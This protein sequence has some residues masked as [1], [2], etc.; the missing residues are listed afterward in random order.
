MSF[1]TIKFT[2]KTIVLMSITFGVTWWFLEGGPWIGPQLYGPTPS[3][4]V[5]TF[6]EV[7]RDR[8]LM[9]KDRDLFEK[10]G[11]NSSDGNPK[12]DAL[13]NAVIDAS[14]IYRVKTCNKK[15]RKDFAKASWDYI[16]ESGSHKMSKFETP[17]DEKV[18]Y[19]I[20]TFLREGLIT[21]RE[22]GGFPWSAGLDVDL[23]M[24]DYY[25]R[26]AS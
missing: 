22:L 17:L 7:A 2:L 20:R 23:E 18:L 13:R 12:R 26:C 25:L 4:D 19:T 9:G 8:A 11:S 3:A 15:A 16:R 21:D 6:E 5:P 10:K 24:R 1:D 14:K